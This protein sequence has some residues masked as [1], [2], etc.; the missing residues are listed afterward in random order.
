[1][2]VVQIT[3]EPDKPKL[4]RVF[5][6]EKKMCARNLS[7]LLML[8]MLLASLALLPSALQAAENLAGMAEE[9]VSSEQQV[10]SMEQSWEAEER[11]MLSS[12][13]QLRQR[14]QAL[15]METKQLQQQLE[16]KQSRLDFHERRREETE[17]LRQG[18]QQ[19]F[20]AVAS[21]IRTDIAGGVPF[22]AQERRE[23]LDSLDKVLL[24]ED[25]A[26]HEKLRRLMEVLQVEAK[27][28]YSAEAYAD[29]I[30]LAGEQLQ[31]D[32]V[33][34]GRVSLFFITPDAHSCGVYDPATKGFTFLPAKYT[35]DIR[36]ALKSING[37]STDPL[38]LLPV[39]RISL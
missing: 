32:L 23:R 22:L 13:E 38:N 36:Q 9:T 5:K 15:Q 1:M 11:K 16:H 4:M 14:Q 35:A 8:A 3:S 27:Y 33:R 37:Q 12:I 28:G 19:W 39:G 20:Y 18:L 31:V 30:P 26:A 6:M 21:T 17:K 2:E 25:T 10:R 7:V 29:S 24:D 34:L